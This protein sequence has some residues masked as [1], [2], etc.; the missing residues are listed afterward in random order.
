VRFDGAASG[1]AAVAEVVP[2]ADGYGIVVS[3]R[4]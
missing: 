3:L 4:R 2:A 1:C